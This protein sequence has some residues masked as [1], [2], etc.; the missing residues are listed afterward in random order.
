[1]EKRKLLLVAISVGI[2]LFFIIGVPLLLINPGQQKEPV[3]YAV[4]PA[5]T[6]IPS[7]NE[8]PPVIVQELNLEAED[9]EDFIEQSFDYLDPMDEPE[10]TTITGIKPQSVAVPDIS[11][12]PAAKTVQAA[13]PV[14]S[15]PA[16]SQTT[17]AKPPVQTKPVQNETQKKQPVKESPKDNKNSDYWIQAGAFSTKVSAQGAKETLDSK[18][19]KSIIDNR[20]I[21]GKTWYRVRVGPYVS[22]SEAKFWLPLVKSIN[23][24]DNSMIFLTQR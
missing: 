11:V 8:L 21:D 5:S 2:A 19:V 17:Q 22:E 6:D 1:M 23:G 7:I 14:S 16:K 9:T 13:P 10:I 18:G 3:S 12:K 4:L 15:G 24:F 20:D